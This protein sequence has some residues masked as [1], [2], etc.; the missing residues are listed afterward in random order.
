MEYLLDFFH[1]SYFYL[2]W[3]VFTTME[4]WSIPYSHGT[5]L[6]EIIQD[7][8]QVICLYSIPAI[9]KKWKFCNVLVFLHVFILKKTQHF[10]MTFIHFYALIYVYLLCSTYM[11]MYVGRYWMLK[12]MAFN[13]TI[14]KYILIITKNDLVIS[15]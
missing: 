4:Y 6:G 9:N 7:K 12:T 3:T 5:M 8:G 11:F 2:S 14:S 15:S 10:L 13:H 1:I